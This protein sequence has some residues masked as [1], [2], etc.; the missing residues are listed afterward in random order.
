MK[1]V[2]SIGVQPIGVT[3]LT[4]LYMSNRVWKVRFQEYGNKK[5]CETKHTGPH[6]HDEDYVIK[7]F[8]LDGSDIMWYELTE[9][10]E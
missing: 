10:T 9:I 8:G 5:I 6:E 7:H 3:K 4:H 2:D 1:S